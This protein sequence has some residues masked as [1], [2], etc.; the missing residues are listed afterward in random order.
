MPSGAFWPPTEIDPLR[1]ARVAII[2]ERFRY[3][4]SAECRERFDAVAPQ[5]PLPV[6]RRQRVTPRT[7]QAFELTADVMRNA[8]NKIMVSLGADAPRVQQ[9]TERFLVDEDG[10]TVYS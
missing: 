6:P 8:A 10:Q 1:A 2:R 4:C 7:W 3:Y 5:T 9:G